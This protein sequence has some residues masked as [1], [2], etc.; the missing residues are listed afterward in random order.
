MLPRRCQTRV[1]EDRVI[2]WLP[3][4]MPSATASPTP[5]AR[6][7]NPVTAWVSV[8]LLCLGF[9]IAYIDRTNLSIALASPAFKQ[10][11]HLSDSERGWLNSAF[12]WSYALLQI[13]AGYVTDRYGVR[14]PYAISFLLWSVFSAL[15]A[16]ATS[17]WQ[18]VGCRILLGIGEAIVTPASLRWIALGIPERH[19]GLAV[20]ILYAGSKLGPAAGAWLAVHL[21]QSIGWQGMFLILGLGGL[22]FLVPWFLVLRDPPSPVVAESSKRTSD[23]DFRSI[24]TTP[25]IYGILLGTLA[26]NYF[27]YFNLTWL[28]AYFVERWKLSLDKMGFY[29]TFSFLGMALMSVLGGALADLVIARGAKPTATRRAFTILGLSIAATEIVGS[30]TTSRDVAVAF[31]MISMTGLGLATANY[32]ALTQTL[33]PKSVI[34]RVAGVQNFASNLG[35]VVAPALTGWLVQTTGS[36]NAPMQAILL[37]LV[38]GIA[39]YAL[40]V[41]EKYRPQTAA[42]LP[43]PGFSPRA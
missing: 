39:A 23:A 22:L 32:W 8:S 13:P 19:R 27:N 42:A 34:G 7:Y 17:F 37:V 20:G 35:G 1:R 4:H 15:T 9:L 41:R 26:Y 11:F 43:E 38:L 5:P 30:L 25:A 21:I 16:Y 10:A 12:F 6:P 33:M 2:R 36:Y 14:W 28:P 18:L 31:A 24:W 3:G 29:T 40:V